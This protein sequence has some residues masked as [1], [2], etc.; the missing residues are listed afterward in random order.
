MQE[1][2]GQADAM[3]NAI[4]T[5]PGVERVIAGEQDGPFAELQVQ[6][7]D[8]RDIREAIGQKL[9]SN[10]WPLRRL[11]LRRSSLE[12]RFIQAVNREA[13]ADARREAS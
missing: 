9:S 3:R 10:G 4:Q 8:G 7:R 2:I 11:D 1:R 13:L 12:E 5:V 6:T